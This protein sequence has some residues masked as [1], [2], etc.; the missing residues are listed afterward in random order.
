MEIVCIY[1]GVPGY[2]QKLDYVFN[3]FRNTLN[4]IG[5]TV[6]IINIPALQLGYFDGQKQPIIEEILYNVKNE[7]AIIFATTAQRLAVN[8]AMQV[9]LEHLDKNLYSNAFKDK[10]VISIITSTDGSE[11]TA[12]NYLS[13]LVDNFGA[14]N[15]NSMLIGNSY[16]QNIES[17]E[18]TIQMIEKYAE[19]FYRLAK[20]NRKFFIASPFLERVT[21]P[22]PQAPTYGGSIYSDVVQPMGHAPQTYAPNQQHMNNMNPPQQEQPNMNSEQVAGLYK[23]E[24]DNAN[25]MYNNEQPQNNEYITPPVNQPR[26]NP[27]RNNVANLYAKQAPPRQKPTP[28]PQVE[29]PKPEIPVQPENSPDLTNLTKLLQQRYQQDETDK[30][31]LKHYMQNNMKPTPAKPKNAEVSP[32]TNTL[33]Q[34]TQSLYHYFQPHLSEGVDVSIQISIFGDET[35]NGCFVIKNAECLY[36]DG[37]NPNADV[38]IISDANIWSDVLSSKYTLQKAF[39]LGRLKVKGNFVIISRFEQLFKI[40]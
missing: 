38:S 14:T 28:P 39:M 34:K 2:E 5:S 9:F 21:P 12:G 29:Q 27:P 11:Y 6:K 4:E 36:T 18:T 25:Y 15:I 17:S 40:I 8:G 33:K 26:Q 22:Q 13:S 30:L 7:Q 35:F 31:E 23:K 24:L 32:S 19:D 37:I 3:I 16:L 1:A 20:Q 10:P